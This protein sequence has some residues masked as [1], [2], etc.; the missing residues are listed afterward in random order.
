MVFTTALPVFDIVND[1]DRSLTVD[2][3]CRT[4]LLT[5]TDN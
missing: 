5:D 4:L 1:I 3:F 2:A